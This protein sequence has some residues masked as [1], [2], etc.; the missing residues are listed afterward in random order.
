MRRVVLRAHGGPECIAFED[1]E[2]GAPGP[3]EVCVRHHAIGLNFLDTYHRSGLYPLALPSGLGTEAAGEIIAVGADVRDLQVG[4]RVA[5]A[6]GPLGAYSEARCI[7]AEHVVKLPPNVDFA[8]AAATMLKGMT[9]YYLLFETFALSRGHVALVHAAAGGVGSL[10]VPW[11]VQRGARV[12]GVARGAEKQ[13]AARTSGCERVLDPSDPDFV[14][15][16]R[17]STGGAG[18]D[19]VYDSVGRATWELSLACLRPRGLMVSYGNASGKPPAIE[20]GALAARGS[21]YLT[22]P[23][24]ADYIRTRPQLE[25]AANAV[26]AALDGGTLRA[27]IRQ[28][29]RLAE[30]ASA[31]RELES[32]ALR[33][34]SVILP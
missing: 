29:Y 17:A 15:K 25:R 10:L 7:G 6:G 9:A 21:L 30:V 19:V 4:D 12:I 18:V 11:A 28:R 13:G 32:G 33:G 1:H 31:H 16:V 5:Y 3:G 8:T 26:F 34:L 20:P 27:P 2:P 24:L 14:A 23:I 22:R